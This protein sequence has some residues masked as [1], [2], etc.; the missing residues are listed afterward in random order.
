MVVLLDEPSF[1]PSAVWPIVKQDATTRNKQELVKPLD[2]TYGFPGEVPRARNQR[3]QDKL[4]RFFELHATGMS[5][6]AAGRKVG[7][8]E[9]W[10]KEY[11]YQWLKRYHPYVNWLQAHVAQTN[12]RQL[13]IEQSD[14]L[15]QI[16]MIGMANDYDYLVFERKGK[17]I[18]VRWK[19]L[20][21]LTRE[22][23]VPIEVRGGRGGKPFTYHWRDRDGKL[24][25]LGKSLGMFNERILLEHRHSHLHVSADLSKVPMAQ[26]KALE[27][28][29]ERLLTHEEP[30]GAQGSIPSLRGDQDQNAGAGKAAGNGED[31]GGEDYQLARRRRTPKPPTR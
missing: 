29:F 25:E 26:L 23:M 28:E 2:L 6:H 30:L 14:V 21:E 16:A 13:A 24:F 5:A 9:K 17:K 4:L 3:D 15:N 19:D 18:T 20:H 31:L 1:G 7:F 12:V 22:Q 27:A 8:S 10:A 11:S